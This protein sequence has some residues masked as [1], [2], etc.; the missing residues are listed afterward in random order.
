MPDTIKTYFISGLGADHRVFSKLEL[1]PRIQIIH[2]PWL[3]PEDDESIEHYAGRMAANIEDPAHS[4]LLGLSFGG[5]MAHEIS[6][7]MPVRKLILLSSIKHAGEMPPHLQAVRLTQAHKVVP[8]KLLLSNHQAAYLF[9]GSKTNDEKQMLRTL[10]DEADP[11]I[12][13]W[14]ID[15]LVNWQR[16]E[17]PDQA[18]HIHGTADVVFPLKHVKAD[19]VVEDGPHFMVYTFPERVGEILN[20][21]ILDQ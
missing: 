4:V 6:R 9:F 19:F 5:V 11:E 13:R 15:R 3:K 2:L 12:V 21:V 17:G 14:S 1:D 16:E 18:V 7:L 8:P 20:Q 10:L